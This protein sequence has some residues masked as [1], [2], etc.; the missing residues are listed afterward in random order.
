[1]VENSVF[2]LLRSFADGIGVLGE[3]KREV[4]A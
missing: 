4:L 2:L 3:S 1:M